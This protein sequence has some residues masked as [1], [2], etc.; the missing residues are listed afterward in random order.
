SVKNKIQS[1]FFRPIEPIFIRRNKTDMPSEFGHF[2]MAH[3]IFCGNIKGVALLAQKRIIGS[4]HDEVRNFYFIKIW[5]AARFFPII[6]SISKTINR[7]SKGIV[8]ILEI[9]GVVNLSQVDFRGYQ[10]FLFS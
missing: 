9:P 10:A 5:L 4:I 6:R 8:K 3:W 2:Q 1:S 7:S